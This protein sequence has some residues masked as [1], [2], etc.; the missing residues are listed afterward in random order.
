MRRREFLRA[1]GVVGTASVLRPQFLFGAPRQTAAYFNLHPFVAAHPEAVFIRLTQVSAK[2]ATAEKVQAGV[3]LARELFVASDQSGFSTTS[4]IAV[5]PNLT[6]VQAPINEA[7]MGIPTD[8]D[9]VEGFIE[10]MKGALGMD[11]SRF[12]IREGNHL[13]DSYCPENGAIEWYAPLA[14]RTGAHLLDFDSGR[15]MADGA[16]ANLE[17]G[18]EVIWREV[19]NGVVYKRVGY[20][21][22]MNAP[23]GFNI[24]IAKFKAHGM[25]ITL[26][27]K[28]WQ[29]T[30]VHPYIHYCSDVRGQ[31]RAYA[32]SAGQDV[33]PDYRTTLQTLF[34]QH[35]EAG[36]PRW[37]KPGNIDSW[38][39]GPGMEMWSNKT[40][41]NLTASTHNLCIIEGI[42]G[43]DGNWEDGPHGGLAADFMS[44]VLVF[45]QNPI[46][47]D[48]IG[49]WLAGQE[50][51]NF[52]LFH[53]ARDRGMTGTINPR[54][55]PLYG[56]EGGQPVR[57]SLDT[58]ARTPLATYYMQRNYGGQSEPY[59]HLV[60]E[61]FDYG[62]PTAV[63]ADAQATPNSVV[64]AQNYPNPF[65][66]ATVIE[67]RLPQAGNARIEVFNARGQLVQVLADRWHD[68]G[69]HMVSWDAAH[70]GSGAYFYRFLTEGFQET[71]KM[72]LVR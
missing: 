65:N 38:N 68:A 21:A 70:Q 6:C 58:F 72:L 16:L 26:C 46:K 39:S 13:G 3:D 45:G 53:V 12:Y 4:R 9:F 19:P 32:S 10:G 51:G 71:R 31:F 61:P 52:G 64:L 42:Y 59:W 54:E 60:D 66:A 17:E 30:N 67:Y 2:T 43:H 62:P 14:E 36:V 24:N 47:V 1:A 69:A 48:I 22:P 5:K 28:N 23:D 41:D 35:L 7:R 8:A 55:I 50:P 11:G 25:G 49:H 33:Q 29:G 15:L 18:S 57:R 37:D 56:W 63:L 40:L 27:S 20:V 34:T 44:N